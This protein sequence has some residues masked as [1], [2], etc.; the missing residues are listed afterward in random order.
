MEHRLQTPLRPHGAPHAAA[1]GPQSP[2]LPP[3]PRALTLAEV[4]ARLGLGAARE[5]GR[6]RGADQLAGHGGAG[7]GSSPAADP[8]PLGFPAPPPA[9]LPDDAAPAGKE[10]GRVRLPQPGRDAFSGRRRR[11]PRGGAGASR[12]G[13]CTAGRPLRA[14][15]E[16]LRLV[17]AAPAGAA[18]AGHPPTLLLPA[19]LLGRELLGCPRALPATRPL[20]GARQHLL[21]RRVLLAAQ[22]LL[23][24]RRV[25]LA[26]RRQLPARRELLGSRPEHPPRRELCSACPELLAARGLPPARRG[27]PA[28][29]ELPAARELPSP[30]WLQLAWRLVPAGLRS[31]GPARW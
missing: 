3:R 7:S 20:P 18:S 10:R 30:S 23:P 2:A 8:V 27:L 31:A 6:Q 9:A 14:R 15:H 11:A 4:L 5:A 13:V 29:S 17:P 21:V 25:L 1:Q 26:T 19:A 28:G 22:E 24:A 16:P 12:S